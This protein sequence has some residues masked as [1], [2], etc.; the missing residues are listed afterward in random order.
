M[1]FSSRVAGRS[2]NPTK[3][4][5]LIRVTQYY[6]LDE[7]LTFDFSTTK[8]SYFIRLCTTLQYKVTHHIID[9]SLGIIFWIHKSIFMI[10][11][12][13]MKGIR[14]L[15]T[16]TPQSLKFTIQLFYKDRG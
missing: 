8:R 14:T 4:H 13:L 6:R 16:L 1:F 5:R 12:N 10:S 15:L 11:T 7:N 9:A 3:G 2:H